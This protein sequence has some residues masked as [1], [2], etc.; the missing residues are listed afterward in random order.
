[1]SSGVPGAVMGTCKETSGILF[2]R[3]CKAP[4]EAKCKNC[5]KAICVAHLRT[6]NEQGKE[7]QLCIGCTRGHLKSRQRRGSYAHLRDD[8]YFY[9]YS[10]DRRYSWDDDPYDSD[11]FDLFDRE[12]ESPSTAYTE[13]SDDSV[14]EST[15]EGS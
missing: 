5:K 1:M 3:R 12:G 9:W 14:S 11:D 6:L 7:Y 13:T 10:D 15:W 8:P 4:A 2:S